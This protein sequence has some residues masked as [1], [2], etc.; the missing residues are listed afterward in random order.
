M[1]FEASNAAAG[2]PSGALIYRAD[3]YSFDTEPAAIGAFTSATI[4]YLSLELDSHGKIVSVWGLC[5]HNRWIGASLTVPMA[6]HGDI[7]LVP[8][9]P[10]VPGGSMGIGSKWPVLVDRSSGWV[11]VRGDPAAYTATNI[12]PGVI[13]ELSRQGDIASVWLKPQS[14]P[15]KR[16]NEK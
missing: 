16:G 13:V 8:D 2:M 7:V 4:D 10:L 5:P 1:R 6:E 9:S 12:L 11:C 14:L 15:R 3:E